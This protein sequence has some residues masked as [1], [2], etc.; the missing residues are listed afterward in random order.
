MRRRICTTREE[1]VAALMARRDEL[2]LTNAVLEAIS[3]ISDGYAAKV[4][5]LTPIR[6]LGPM[7][8]E[9]ILGALGLGIC[10]I[11]IAADPEAIAQVAHRWEPR[12]GR[13]RKQRRAQRKGTKHPPAEPE[14][15]PVVTDRCVV[16]QRQTEFSF[17]DIG[18][19]DMAKTISVR[20]DTELEE[21]VTAAAAKERRPVSQYLRN[22]LND[23]IAKPAPGDEASK[24]EVAA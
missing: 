17:P 3:G 7:S 4:L 24:P 10:A 15:A 9:A 23:A 12:R 20:V 11:T 16:G 13:P 8:L 6:R 18:E 14:P 2:D 22:V 1:L 5:T 19:A 21:R